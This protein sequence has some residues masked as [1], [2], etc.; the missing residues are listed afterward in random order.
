MSAQAGIANRQADVNSQMQR[1]TLASCLTGLVA[2]VGSEV[3]IAS[4]WGW[5][6]GGPAALEF[7]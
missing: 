7:R 4:G 5:R 1:F 2:I 3:K 6:K